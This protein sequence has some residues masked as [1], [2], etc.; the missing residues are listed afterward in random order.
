MLNV[1]NSCQINKLLLHTILLQSINIIF[2]KIDNKTKYNSYQFIYAKIQYFTIKF[3]E[4]LQY[5][6]LFKILSKFLNVL[7]IQA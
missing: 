4:I 2:F 5:L 7:L 3:W 1:C 6:K